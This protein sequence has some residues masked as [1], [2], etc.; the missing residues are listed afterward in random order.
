MIQHSV[1]VHWLNGNER[2]SKLKVFISKSKHICIR[3]ISQSFIIY[4]LAVGT[5]GSL[6]LL[7]Q[8]WICAPGTH[9]SWVNRGTVGCEVW[10]ILLHMSTWFN[11]YELWF[12][13]ILFRRK[14]LGM[15]YNTIMPSPCMNMNVSD[16]LLSLFHLFKVHVHWR[17]CL[18]FH[19]WSARGDEPQTFWLK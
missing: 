5:Y 13:H 19:T 3:I 14:G 1:G 2:Y 6:Q 7:I 11:V 10:L 15:V 8:P 16:P 17:K 4:P 9:C 18:Y 12:K